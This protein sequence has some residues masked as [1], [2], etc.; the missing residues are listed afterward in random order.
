MTGGHGEEQHPEED[1]A[2]PWHHSTAKVLGASVAG[3]AA[4]GLVVGGVLFVS[5]QADETPQAPTNFVD[6]SFSATS[7]TSS[8]VPP[9]SSTP[10][11]PSNPQ[12][13]DI[14][15]PPTSAPPPPPPPSSTS[16]ESTSRRTPTTRNNDDDDEDEST[17]S[18]TRKRPRLNETRTPS[19]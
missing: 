2:T 11:R 17:P 4:I 5:R 12:T 14:D 1:A 7:D 3:L 10:N 8:S 15:L 18:S 6:P 16:E 13:T 9:T 19:N